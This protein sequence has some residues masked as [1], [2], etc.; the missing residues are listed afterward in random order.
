MLDELPGR[1]D[2][3]QIAVWV[4]ADE[5]REAKIKSDA[6]HRRLSFLDL[7]LTEKTLACNRSSTLTLAKIHEILDITHGIV[8]VTLWNWSSPG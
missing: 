6:Q 1:C 5:S 4:D 2:G 8:V 7:R 3:Q